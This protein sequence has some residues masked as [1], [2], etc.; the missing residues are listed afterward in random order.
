MPSTWMSSP[1]VGVCVLCRFSVQKR[2][3]K[4]LTSHNDDDSREET[5]QTSGDAEKVEN[6]SPW[7][8]VSSLYDALNLGIRKPVYE[9]HSTPTF[10][11]KFSNRYTLSISVCCFT[12]TLIDGISTAPLW[13]FSKGQFV[14]VLTVLDFILIMCE[15]GSHGSNLTEEELETHTISAWKEAKLYLNK[16]IIEH[17]LLQPNHIHCSKERKSTC[18]KLARRVRE[19][20]DGLD[21][22]YYPHFIWWKEVKIS[23]GSF[24]L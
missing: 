24:S 8:S 13:D 23:A 11:L 19:L 12:V 7:K 22:K 4:T 1:T 10:E 20:N 21:D 5:P 18:S 2:E 14:G 17:A 9:F 15:L 3:A 6:G 16:Q